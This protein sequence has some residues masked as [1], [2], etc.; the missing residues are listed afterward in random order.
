MKNI[1]NLSIFQNSSGKKLVL[2]QINNI[3]HFL[4]IFIHTIYCEVWLKATSW[5]QNNLYEYFAARVD[6]CHNMGKEKRV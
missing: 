4:N 6:F 1:F 5:D 2:Y 3:T